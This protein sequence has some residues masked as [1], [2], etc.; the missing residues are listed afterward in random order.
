[1]LPD[2]IPWVISH[3][4]RSAKTI[5]KIHIVFTPTKPP[6]ED[7][8]P[9]G[10]AQWARID[11]LVQQDYTAVRTFILEFQSHDYTQDPGIVEKDVRAMIPRMVENP[12][13]IV[14]VVLADGTAFEL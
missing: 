3:P 4:F 12:S 10:L 11:S 7:W 6:N 1:M 2:I 9:Y 5:T 14:R 13:I 8:R